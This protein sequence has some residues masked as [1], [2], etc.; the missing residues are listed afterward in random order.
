MSHLSPVNPSLWQLLQVTGWK[1]AS[2]AVIRWITSSQD[3]QW[4]PGSDIIVSRNSFTVTLAP[5]S[6]M[7]SA[8]PLSSFM[9]KVCLSPTAAGRRRMS[10]RNCRNRE[11]ANKKG[12]SFIL[13]ILFLPLLLLI[14]FPS[15]PWHEMSVAIGQL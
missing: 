9:L 13:L 2:A 3:T 12:V 4:G 14:Y 1:T 7:S 11:L 15:P 6:K 8:P 10:F 5:G